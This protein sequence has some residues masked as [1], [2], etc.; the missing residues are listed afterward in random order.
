MIP[1]EPQMPEALGALSRGPRVLVRRAGAPRKDARCVV[2]SMQRAMRIV[3]NPALDVTIAAGNLLDL[4]VVVYFRVISNYP[5]ANLRHYHFL[6]QGLRDVA[7]DAAERGVGFVV[8][9]H[10]D[11]SLEAFLEEVDAA[12]V[13]GDENPCREPERWR[14][15]LA[16]RLRIPFWTVDAD[17]VVPSR[18]FDR[19]FVL[20]HHFRPHL[21]A[22]LPKYLVAPRKISPLRPWKPS[23]PLQSFDLSED[24]TSGF[25]KL[26]R[27][28]KP[29]DSFTG[30]THAALK[31]LSE[32]V[33]LE[34][35]NYPE[36][37]NHPELNGTSR[38]SPWL[39]F[40]NIGPLT[41]ALAVNKASREDSSGAEAPADCEGMKRGLKPPPPSATC[42]SKANA[43]EKFLDELIGWRELA[44][45]FV[46]HEPNY[47]NWECAAPWA[48]KSLI[49][50]AGDPR[51]Y[52]YT[53]AQLERGETHDHLW[54]AAQRQMVDTGWM[55]GY[56]RMYWAKKIL[57]WAPDPAAAF[58]WALTLND[59]YELDGRDPSGYAGIAWAIVG[60]HDR[61]WFNRP[62]FGLVRTMTA[63]ST[64]KK[65]DSKLYIRQHGC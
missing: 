7:E 45:L 50:H 62:I 61:P 29:V 26:D 59:R 34:L 24:I 20:L 51:P 47:D 32:F 39:H 15:V 10:P 22:A 30:G 38:L 60:R 19:S 18:V 44:V 3:D 33:R 52:R 48:R 28:V 14:R 63:N 13:I 25:A 31:R 54:N 12:L 40:G 17:V 9:R 36:A 65:F 56:M 37:R 23:K 21:K 11:N 4:P 6:Q 53:L 16:R 58:D 1:T 55:H 46:R 57:E 64:A 27:K 35:K 43:A 8:R 42:N 49:E 5:N 41:I 2:Y